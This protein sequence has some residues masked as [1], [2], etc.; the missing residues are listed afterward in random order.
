MVTKARHWEMT[1]ASN[2]SGNNIT[3]NSSFVWAYWREMGKAYLFPAAEEGPFFN[4]RP[5]SGR[6]KNFLK[7]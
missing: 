6:C 3:V 2:C 4:P 7:T 5:A 1:V